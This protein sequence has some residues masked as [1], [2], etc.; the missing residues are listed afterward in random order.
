M[1]VVMSFR[2][3]PALC[4]ESDEDEGVTHILSVTAS[5]QAQ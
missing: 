2:A 5:V 4:P 1:L 3:A